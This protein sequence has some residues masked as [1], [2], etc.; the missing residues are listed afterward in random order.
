MLVKMGDLPKPEN[1]VLKEHF[2]PSKAAQ[3][4]QEQKQLTSSSFP[5]VPE[6]NASSQRTSDTSVH[7]AS[8][9]SELGKRKAEEAG[10]D[11]TM[12]R[13]DQSAR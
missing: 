4:R 13:K 8:G 5:P 10:V 1:N 9:A 12:E 6:S 7:S 3:E 11:V 2:R